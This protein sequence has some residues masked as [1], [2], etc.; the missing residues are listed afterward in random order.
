MADA[1][2]HTGRDPHPLATTAELIACYR[3]GDTRAGNALIARFRPALERWARGQLPARVR[4]TFGLDTQD[5]VQVTFIRAFENMRGFE[6]RHEGAL[7]AYLRTIGRHYLID[8]I[9]AADRRPEIVELD[10]TLPD[11]GET[12]IEALVGR[13]NGR[14]L[15]RALAQ[16]PEAQAQAFLLRVEYGMSYE[17]IARHMERPS[18]ESARKLVERATVRL[19]KHMADDDA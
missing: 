4:R 15:E 16:L 6:S 5:L 7:L 10:A 13:E 9:R 18:S 1:P 2:T 11:A 17:E 12:P 14:R 8:K 19:V 3:A